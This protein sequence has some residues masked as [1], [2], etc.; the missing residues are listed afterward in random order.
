MRKVYK[1]NWHLINVHSDTIF[2]F[3]LF[4]SIFMKHQK[5]LLVLLQIWNQVFAAF[6]GTLKGNH[7]KTSS[8]VHSSYSP[9]KKCLNGILKLQSKKNNQLLLTFKC[10]TTMK[11][12]L[13]TRLS[14]MDKSDNPKLLFALYS[15]SILCF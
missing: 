8:L 5:H 4:F 7:L 10:F 9:L 3:S 1:L 6:K 14:S 2:S 11:P 13:T 12:A 15:Q